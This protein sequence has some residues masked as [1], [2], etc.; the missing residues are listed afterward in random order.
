MC[1]VRFPTVWVGTVLGGMVLKRIQSQGG[2]GYG[3]PTQPPVS[4]LT[5]ACEN[6]TFPQLL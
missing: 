4:R 3:P 1:T 6:I 5:D 2:R